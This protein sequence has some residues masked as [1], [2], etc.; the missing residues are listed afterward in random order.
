[1]NL[2][3]LIEE[4]NDISM[5]EKQCTQALL[6]T[7]KNTLPLFKQKI[8]INCHLTK[9]TLLIVELF[10]FSGAEVKVTCTDDLVCH[11]PI[12]EIINDLGIYLLP[13]ELSLVAY[14]NYFDVILD[15]GAYLANSLVPRKGFVEL[16][17][18]E[19]SRYQTTNCPVISVDNSFIKRLET[20]F[21][22]GDGFV[23]AIKELSLKTSSDYRLKTY[24][25]FGYGKVGE[26]ICACLHRALVPKDRI[27][28]VEANE[29][30]RIAAKNKGFRAYS[31]SQDEQ[32]IKQLLQDSI[33]CAVTAT[34][35]KGSIS[36]YFSPLDFSNVEYLCNMGTYD[37]WGDDFAE[38]FILHKKR[39]LNFM[40]DYPTK[41]LYLDPIFALLACATLDIVQQNTNQLF[42]I[43]KPNIVTQRK[44]LDVWLKNNHL[45]HDVEQLW[46]QEKILYC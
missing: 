12:K 42:F 36:Q 37:E 10:L 34:G 43:Q 18:V 28:V 32:T 30:N 8:L 3:K 2:L 22:T 45:H 5:D 25:I 1:M 4:T 13:D 9:A 26:G 29:E 33:S 20:S 46:A 21:G 35:I 31:I 15:C 6:N 41:I 38:D 44:V 27:I 39:P 14:K 24:L 19:N 17:H 16:T 40:L 7:W 11:E 23:R